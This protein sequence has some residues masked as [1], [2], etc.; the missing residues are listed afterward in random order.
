MNAINIRKE[1]G[2]TEMIYLRRVKNI[3]KLNREYEVLGSSG[4]TYTIWIHEKPR[5][6][7]PDFQGRSARCKH[8]YYV[9]DKILNVDGMLIDKEEFSMD[10]LEYIFNVKKDIKSND[11]DTSYLDS[12][13][14]KVT[15]FISCFQ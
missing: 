1:K 8:I 14:N 2:R 12:I 13:Y 11:D 15:S 5:C 4:K 10:E 7:C 6:T 3:S 9:L